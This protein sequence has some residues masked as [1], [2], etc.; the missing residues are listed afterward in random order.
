MIKRFS[1]G[2]IKQG[3]PTPNT[4]KMKHSMSKY[5]RRRRHLRDGDSLRIEE[6]CHRHGIS[7]STYYDLKRRGLGP[8][9]MRIGRR[10]I[11][12]SAADDRDWVAR[13]QAGA[14]TAV[15]LFT[16]KSPAGDVKGRDGTNTVARRKEGRSNERGH[17]GAPK[18][19]GL[20]G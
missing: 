18:Y 3:L 8:R 19:P 12:I 11:R 9:E 4:S 13:M 1:R 2:S 5:R 17:G 16:S 10:N 14:V 7:R 15:P 6:F 20:R